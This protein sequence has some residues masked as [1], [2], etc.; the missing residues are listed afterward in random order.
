MLQARQGKELVVR[1]LNQV[2]VLNRLAKEL[3]EKGVSI[4]AMSCWVYD[5]MAV[6]HIVTD[7]NLRARQALEKENLEVMEEDAVIVDAAHKPGL[8][9]HMTEVLRK[10][11]INLNHLYATAHENDDKA[12][13]VFSSSDNQKALVE[14]NRD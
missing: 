12:V 4:L 2:G 8:L 5:V 1:A 6:F 3:S 14:L 9:H 10:A 13:V 11:D 7:D